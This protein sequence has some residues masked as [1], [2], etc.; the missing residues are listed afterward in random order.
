M[1][2]YAYVTD[3][4]WTDTRQRWWVNLI[5]TLSLSVRSFMNSDL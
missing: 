3:G 4:V 5:K 2:W 1:S